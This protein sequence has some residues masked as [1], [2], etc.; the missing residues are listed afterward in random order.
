MMSDRGTAATTA[1]ACA[2]ACAASVL[3]WTAGAAEAA[4]KSISGFV[5]GLAGGLPAVD[6]VGGSFNQPRDVAVYEGVDGDPATDKIFVVEGL[7]A[8]SRVQRLDVDG[9]FERVWG[10]DVIRSGAPGDTGSGFEICTV[11]PDCKAAAPTG[12]LKGEMNQPSGVAVDQVDGW[13]YVWDRQNHRIQ[14]FDLD[15]SFILT[16]GRNVNQTTAGDVCTQ[17]SGDV[18]KAGITTPTGAAGVLNGGTGTPKLDVSPVDGHV[19]VTDAANRRINDFQP[20]GT[21]VRAWGWDVIPATGVGDLGATFEICTAASTCKQALTTAGTDNGRFGSNHPQY[22]AVDSSG[23]VYASD[24]NVNGRVLRFDSTQATAAALLETPIAAVPD[25]GPLLGGA[26]VSAT[27]SLSLEIDR[28]SDGGGA[29]EEHLLAVRDPAVDGLDTVVQ[30]LDLPSTPTDPVTTVVDTHTFAP[31]PVNGGIGVNSR[32]GG[33]YLPIA[34]IADQFP[35][36]APPDTSC[37]GLFVLAEGGAEPPVVVASPPT[38]VGAHDASFEGTVDPDGL[39]GFHFEY[40]RD[41]VTWT[42]TGV[43]RYVSGGSPVTVTASVDGLEAGTLYRVRI[44]T[45]KYMGLASKDVVSSPELT[46]ATDSLPPEAETL[47]VSSRRSTSATLQGRVNPNGTS[48]SYHFQYGRT[49]GYGQR[50]PMPDGNAGSGGVAKL[51]SQ[52]VSGLQPGTT[53]HYRVVAESSLGLVAGDDRTF[54]TRSAELPNGRGFELVSPADKLSGSG[55]GQHLP[56]DFAAGVTGYA[57][58]DGERYAIEATRGGVLLD[59]EFAYANDWAFAERTQDGWR[60]HSPF[61][62]SNYGYAGNRFANLKATNEELSTVIWGTN[63]G[64]GISPFPEMQDWADSV[65]VA[66]ISDWDGDW[67][68]LAPTDPAQGNGDQSTPRAV[69]AD[70]SAVAISS[71]VRGLLSTTDPTLDLVTGSRSTYVKHLP[72]GLDDTF[73]GAGTY[74]AVGACSA[75]TEIPSRTD[76]GGGVFKLTPQSCPAQAGRDGSVT[77]T[78]GASLGTAE[79]KELPDNA[80]SQD[81][82]RVFFM[83][84]DPNAPGLPGAGCTGTGATSLCPPQLY[85]R[86]FNSTGDPVTR[87]IS[88]STVANQDATLAGPVYF[89]GASDDGDK[90]LFRTNMPLTPDDPNGT[91]GAPCTTG[92]PSG[93]SWD[94]YLYDLPD[95]ADPA[96]GTLTRITAGPTGSADVNAAADAPAQVAALRYLSTDASRAYFVTAAPLPGAAVPESGTTTSPGGATNTT[97]AANLYLYDANRAPAERW[98][99]VARIPRQ[100]GLHLA[101]CASTAMS[102]GSPIAR[103]G[104]ATGTIAASFNCVQGSEDGAFVTLLTD[105]RLTA[106]DPDATSGDVY[107]FDAAVEELTR[108]SAPQGGEGGVYTCITL[109]NPRE[110]YADGGIGVEA[111]PA[112]PRLGMATDPD[113]GERVVFLQSKSRLTPDDDDDVYDVYEWRDGDLALLTPD[114]EHGAYYNG[115]S[116]DGQ[117]VFVMTRERLTWEDSDAVMDIY[118]AR[119]GGGFPEPEP[120]EPPCDPLS[121]ACQGPTPPALGGSNASG[122]PGGGGNADPGERATLELRGLTAK[123]RARAARRGVVAIPVAVT[124]AGRVALTAKAR[125][126]S[127]TKTVGRVSKRAKRAGVMRIV[128]RL[129]PGSRRVLRAG[130]VLRLT[131]DVR[132]AGA[133]PD[134][135]TLRLR[136]PGR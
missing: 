70:G 106:D 64:R 11:A 96:G 19:L 3:A 103:D 97:D 107:A 20:D 57:S 98:R 2:I 28:D 51:V 47:A 50:A 8:N 130:R 84:P 94:L 29:D 58:G 118:D 92:A 37:A 16:F 105:G 115:N 53:Y 35:A 113:A 22:V 81:G 80:V 120:Q 95:G 121:D 38:D 59:G 132:Q 111:A 110:C 102:P 126:G 123:Q 72:T 33:I 116:S 99:F 114:T 40:S 93:A 21:F 14:K 15:G 135:M 127:R 119:V 88:R 7:G 82:S 89:E 100:R 136:R 63:G 34:Y 112:R 46:F 71:L 131:L 134:S 83:S 25:G 17:A 86:Q 73:A 125:I 55:V 78:R 24:S 62:H 76:V 67:E 30:E 75:G 31:Q 60:S 129:G 108:V 45:S 91:C 109:V 77:S 85:V 23:I 43:D 101:S 6:F 117:D 48:T 18:C 32:T 12:G 122:Q 87:W 74:A 90:V 49:T 41:G 79:Q 104:N 9:N 128:L 54:A 39:A 52:V 36:C 65:G 133:R 4:P 66:T 5:G 44:V 10:R 68:L 42:P 61:T 13:V 124:R 69:S 27:A 26:N 1:L 56:E